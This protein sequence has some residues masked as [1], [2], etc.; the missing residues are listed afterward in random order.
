MRLFAVTLF[1]VLAFASAAFATTVTNVAVDNTKPS[2]AAGART[3]YAI[4]F[5]TSA[6]GALSE[7]ANSRINIT[8][9]ATASLANLAKPR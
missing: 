7:Q 4:T 6:T 9:P 8:L 1:A 2:N 3:V 5:T